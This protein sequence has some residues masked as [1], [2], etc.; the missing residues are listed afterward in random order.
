MGKYAPLSSPFFPPVE[1]GRR[2]GLPVVANPAVQGQGGGRER[3]G[4]EE[5]GSRGRFP[6]PFDFGEGGP[7]GG[8]SWRRAAVG[9][10]GHG[11]AAVGL[12]GGQGEEGE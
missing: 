7:Q 8:V 3:G 11:G 10:G 5:A 1:Q 2:L 4:K 12:A 6:P 9:G